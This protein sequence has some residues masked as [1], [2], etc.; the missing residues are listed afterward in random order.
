MIALIL[1]FVASI[2]VFF[3]AFMAGTFIFDWGTS[4]QRSAWA[5]GFGGA[6]LVLCFIAALGSLVVAGICAYGVLD[7]AVA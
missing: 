3:G 1:A 5:H 2:L 6:V 4:P 7:A